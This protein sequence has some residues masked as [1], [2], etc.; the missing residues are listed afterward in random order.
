METLKRKGGRPQNRSTETLRAY[1]STAG[2]FTRLAAREAMGLSVRELDTAIDTLL[3]GNRLRRVAQA[4][5]EWIAAQRPSR[6]APLEERIWHAM[7]IN[8]SWSAGDIAQQ[9]GTT[10]SYVY[11]RLRVY[12]AQGFIK[13]YGVETISGA[14]VRIWRLT[15]EASK[16]IDLPKAQEY[17]PDPLVVAAVRLNKLV[18]QGLVRFVDE[19]LEAMTLCNEI[20]KGLGETYG[21]SAQV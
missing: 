5:Y 10:I 19:R 9:A 1:A 15:A 14:R 7:R 2:T 18:C 6:E 17:S 20:L 11:N 12:R 16:Q 3:R 21:E 13:R 8:P 4:T